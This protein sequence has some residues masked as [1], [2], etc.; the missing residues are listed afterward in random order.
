MR[1]D[2][3]SIFH[4]W[5]YV[6]EFVNLFSL[7]EF[8]K[9]FIALLA[10]INP[11]AVI[12]IY[13][14]LTNRMSEETHLRIRKISSTGVFCVLTIS[15]FAGQLILKGFGISLDSF[16]MGGGLLLGIIAYGMMNAKDEQH[17]QTD[18]EE[19]ESKKKGESI[20]LVPITIPLLTGPGSMS[21][22]VIIASKS[23]GFIG[24]SYIIL[25]AIII[26][27]ITY[28]TFKNAN[29]IRNIL[30]TTGMNVM[31]KVFSLLLMALAIELVVDGLKHVFP[32]LTH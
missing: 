4:F 25:S 6:V 19:K 2:L 23:H 16:Q 10:I 27:L 7:S 20:A 26:S 31:S 29:K 9:V 1:D 17:K 32:G 5:S 8:L 21:L 11:P 14:S 22:C 3:Q 12:P 30:G 24:Y 15:A 13:L 18:E 28:V